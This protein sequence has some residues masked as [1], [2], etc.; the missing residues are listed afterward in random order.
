[1]TAGAKDLVAIVGAEHRVRPGRHRQPRPAARQAP[2]VRR[3]ERG[4]AARATG[5]GDRGLTGRGAD[6]TGGVDARADASTRSPTPPRRPS[7]TRRPSTRGCSTAA[8]TSTFRVDTIERADGSR[9]RARRRRPPRRRRDRG[10]R[11]RRPGPPRP[12]VPDAGRAG[13]A[14]DPGR[15]ARRRRGDRAGR[16]SGRSPR[17]ASSRR[18]PAGARRGGRSSAVFWTAPGFA[19]E[20]MHLYLATELRRSPTT[21]ASAP[22]RTSALVLERASRSR[23]DR[24]GRG[25]P[26]PD[27][28]SI[29][30]LLWLARLRRGV[31]GGCS[32]RRAPQRPA[33]PSRSS[34]AR[35]SSE[36]GLRATARRRWVRASL[37]RRSCL[38]L[39]PRA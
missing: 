10:R 31:A 36:R 27:A 26:D 25:R 9:H 34:A 18:R 17:G 6:R 22:T 23:G 32:W 35:Y 30:G 39:W 13:A 7:S 1:M 28:K 8:G 37:V 14:R 33:G 21:A 3:R 12:P 19:T 11:R 15:H 4:L 2:P 16:G 24:R 20:L 5:R 29:V 38:R